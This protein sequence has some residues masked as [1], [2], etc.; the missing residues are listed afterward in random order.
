MD[1]EVIS[2]SFVLNDM[3]D[4]MAYTLRILAFLVKPRATETKALLLVLHL[5]VKHVS[6]RG[7]ELGYFQI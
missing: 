3:P 5:Q 2:I 6:E 1:S 4:R 7:N